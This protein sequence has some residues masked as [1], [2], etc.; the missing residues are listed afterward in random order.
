MYWRESDLLSSP[1]IVECILTNCL[2][3]SYFILDLS[4]VIHY[5]MIFKCCH[6]VTLRSTSVLWPRLSSYKPSHVL[7]LKDKFIGAVFP[8]KGRI[9]TWIIYTRHSEILHFKLGGYIVLIPHKL[10]TT[11]KRLMKWFGSNFPMPGIFKSMR[12]LF[13]WIPGG[14]LTGWLGV[15]SFPRQ[16]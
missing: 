1:A 16:V 6:I 8:L 10:T 15:S 12:V 14:E 9:V 5:S 11:K 7:L 2:H 4:S 13:V 3:L